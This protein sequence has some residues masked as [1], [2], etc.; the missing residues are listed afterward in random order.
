MADWDDFF[1]SGPRTDDKQPLERLQ[2][3]DRIP[4]LRKYKMGDLREWVRA[5][6]PFPTILPKGVIRAGSQIARRIIGPQHIAWDQMPPQALCAWQMGTT[7]EHA[8]YGWLIP[9]DAAG[10]TVI[11]GMRNIA[12]PLPERAG[13]TREYRLFGRFAHAGVGGETGWRVMLK[14]DT[15]AI[16]VVSSNVST[17]AV[18]LNSGWLTS[19]T[20]D[21][22]GAGGSDTPVGVVPLG[23]TDWA[24]GVG[25]VTCRA[26]LLEG[27]YAA[28]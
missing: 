19:A 6:N 5:A 28:A 14:L 12:R 7:T 15:I 25:A 18:D 4:D 3:N 11:A 13:Y 2:D 17:H 22:W 26:A 23:G 9:T 8:L 27:R 1:Q 10:N 24:G 21:G 16:N 20:I